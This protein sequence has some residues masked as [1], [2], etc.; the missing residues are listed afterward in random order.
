M[1]IYLLSRFVG[2]FLWRLLTDYT[3]MGSIKTRT[4]LFLTREIHVPH[5]EG[6]RLLKIVLIDPLYHIYILVVLMADR[7]DQLSLNFELLE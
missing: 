1:L 2:G 3:S 6:A 4:L 7:N 5:S